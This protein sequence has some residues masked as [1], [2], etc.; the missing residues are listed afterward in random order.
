MVAEVAQE[1]WEPVLEH[2]KPESD[3]ETG[4]ASAS[5]PSQPSPSSPAMQETPLVQ[6]ITPPKPL[7]SRG[8]VVDDWRQFK[9]VWKTM[10]QLF[11]NH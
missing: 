8:N 11:H 1:A 7:D 2:D 3:R 9:Q 6:G 5:V 4:G 10:E